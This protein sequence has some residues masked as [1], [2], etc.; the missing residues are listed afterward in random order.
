MLAEVNAGEPLNIAEENLL[1]YI[2]D[3]ENKKIK[4]D[5]LFAVRV[6]GNSMNKKE[7]NGKKITKGS[8]AVVKNTPDGRK[9]RHNFSN[10]KRE[11]QPLNN[12][13]KNKTQ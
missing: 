8:Y 1:G 12:T 13:T 4:K 2:V 10:R 9:R 5:D 11:T 6:D 7:I 3:G